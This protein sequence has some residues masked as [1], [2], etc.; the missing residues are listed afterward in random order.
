MTTATSV[1]VKT[2]SF[3]E[4]IVLLVSVGA[5]LTDIN[6][7]SMYSLYRERIFL[8]SQRMFAV[9]TPDEVVVLKCFPRNRNIVC[10]NIVNGFDILNVC[11]LTDFSNTRFYVYSIHSYGPC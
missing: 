10:Q 3:P 2:S 5:S 9:L 1:N 11:S 4:L 8:P 7:S 6:K